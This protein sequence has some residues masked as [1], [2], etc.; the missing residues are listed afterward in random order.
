[1]ERVVA[2]GT[3]LRW[4]RT[5]EQLLG[6]YEAVLAKPPSAAAS[7]AWTSLAAEDRL[8]H[9]ESLHAQ[10]VETIG[11]TGLSLVGHDGLLPED[12]QR[13]LAGLARRPLTRRPL[14]RLLSGLHRVVTRG[15]ST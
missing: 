11:P 12:A 4:D 7:V 1:V 2:A 5:A 10:L 15:S 14:L 8:G 9:F 3:A 13:T 6:C